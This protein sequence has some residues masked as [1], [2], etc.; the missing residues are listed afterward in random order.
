MYSS[1]IAMPVTT[2]DHIFAFGPIEQ[3]GK[4]LVETATFLETEPAELSVPNSTP[5]DHLPL[6]IT[7]RL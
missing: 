5:S 7:A 4:T 6:I 3:I 1:L 2:L